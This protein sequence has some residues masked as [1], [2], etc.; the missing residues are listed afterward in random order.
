MTKLVFL[1]A[2]PEKFYD[3]A[4]SGAGSSTS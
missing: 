1:Q 3:E 4:F 2:G